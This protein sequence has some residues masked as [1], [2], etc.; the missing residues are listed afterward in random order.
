MSTKV[1]FDVLLV[2]RALAESRQKAQATMMCGLV[3]VNGQRVDKPGAAVAED[4]SVEVRGQALRYVSRGGL[5]LEKAMSIWPIALQDAICMDIGAS[6]GGFTDCLLQNGAKKVYCIDVGESQLDQ[7]LK[8][9]NIVIIDNFNARNLT[10]D[11]FGEKLDGAVIDV[12]FISLTYILGE[13]ASVLDS[14]KHVLAL[15]K[16]QFECESRSV[17]KNG[18]VRDCKIHKRII[19]KIYNFSVSVGLAPKKLTNAPIIKDKNT[20]YV[21]LLEKD[22]ICEKNENLLKCIKI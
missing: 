5:K 10:G 22:G 11:V 6:T 17:G 20:E 19:E 8:D 9:K 1:R 14:G 12:S 13:V 18:I 16:P 4:A 21:I 15:I 7:S 3:F 2:D